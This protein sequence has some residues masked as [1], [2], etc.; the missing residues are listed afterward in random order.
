L[1]N[2]SRFLKHIVL[3]DLAKL[4]LHMDKRLT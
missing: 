3:V 1:A 4:K 2:R